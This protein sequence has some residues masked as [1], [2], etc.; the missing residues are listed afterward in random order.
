MND[1][2]RMKTLNENFEIEFWDGEEKIFYCNLEVSVNDIGKG[3]LLCIMAIIL[4]IPIIVLLPTIP[5]RVHFRWKI[6]IILFKFSIK[7]FN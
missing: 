4:R 6:L 3:N 1:I 2:L 5:F 7:N